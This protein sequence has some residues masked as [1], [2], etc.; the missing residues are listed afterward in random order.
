MGV[1]DIT[2]CQEQAYLKNSEVTI[3]NKIGAY[4]YF[5]VPASLLV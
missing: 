2:L 3:I 1:Y 4:F 5:D